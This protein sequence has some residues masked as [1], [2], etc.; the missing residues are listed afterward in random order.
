[1]TGSG[2]ALVAVPVAEAAFP[3]PQAEPVAQSAVAALHFAVLVELPAA[4][5][6]A[7]PVVG[8]PVHSQP[9][10]AVLP[11]RGAAAAAG[12]SP[13]DAA[14]ARA[15]RVPAAAGRAHHHRRRPV[16]H[17]AT[18]TVAGNNAHDNPAAGS[19]HDPAADRQAADKAAARNPVVRKPVAHNPAEAAVAVAAD[20][21][22]SRAAAGSCIRRARRT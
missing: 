10:V 1:M 4:A 3:V 12:D 7:Q 13:A 5:H 19:S 9:G 21:R 20:R 2:P 16:D 14:A 8:A 11:V 15:D 17:K 6:S 22:R 18:G